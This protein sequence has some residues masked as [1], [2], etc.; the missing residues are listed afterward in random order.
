MRRL[1]F[2]LL[3]ITAIATAHSSSAQELLYTPDSI[4]IKLRESAQ[5]SGTAQSKAVIQQQNQLKLYEDPDPFVLDEGLLI[6]FGWCRQPE[7]NITYRDQVTR[8][9]KQSS[10]ARDMIHLYLY[11]KN[12]EVLKV[13][14]DYM[15]AWATKS[16]LLN[17]Y[18]LGMDTEKNYFPGIESGFCNR[19]WNMILDSMWQTYGLMNFSQ[20]Y[21]TLSQNKNEINITDADLLRLKNWLLHS[22]VPAVNAGFHSWTR[23]ADSHPN[24]GAY[25]RYRSDN[26]LGWCL[27]GLAAAAQATGDEQLMSYVVFGT[28]Y[29]DG[30]SGPYK[31]PSNLIALTPLAIY[32]DGEVYDE[33]I[34]ASQHKGFSYA[35]FSSWA[36]LHTYISAKS[37]YADKKDVNID[38]TEERLLLA[39]LRYSK[40]VSGDVPLPDPEE[41]TNPSYY[42]FV[43]RLAEQW[44]PSQGA[45]CDAANS[46]D[47]QKTLQGPGSTALTTFTCDD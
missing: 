39:F 5:I 36:L 26:H 32:E 22:L 13:A 19:S 2:L 16:T 31:N 15:N 41:T 20:V 44:L 30:F 43:Y 14:Y 23:W 47:H 3:A 46:R 34:R 42:A 12:P 11:T 45:L 29:D 6:D 9:T 27:A 8:L 33:Q 24:S 21:L 18:A 1:I 25:L 35:N 10:Y 28:E 4:L 37:F 40:Y 38:I 17:A 7:R